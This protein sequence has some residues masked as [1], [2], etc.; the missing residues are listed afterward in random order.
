MPYSNVWITNAPPGSQA[1]NTVDDEFRKLRLDLEERLEEKFITDVAVDPWVVRP[2]ILGNVTGKILLLHHSLWVPDS[3]GLNYSRLGTRLVHSS[4]GAASYFCALPLP[5]GV[6]ITQVRYLVNRAGAPNLTCAFESIDFA[7]APASVTHATVS[8][9]V[10]GD[11]IIS[12]SGLAIVTTAV[13]V[14]HLKATLNNN[15]RLSAAE[16]TYNTPDCRVTV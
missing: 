16:V 4:G 15:D 5:V 10:G 14:Y 1:A 7:V 12:S 2:E 3:N 6:T 9:T 11:A 13:R 8:T